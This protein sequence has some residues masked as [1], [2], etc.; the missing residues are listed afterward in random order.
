MKIERTY[1]VRSGTLQPHQ[2]SGSLTISSRIAADPHPLAESAVQPRLQRINRLTRWLD[3]SIRLPIGG[4]TVGWDSIIGLI[5][6]VGDL[7]TGSLSLWI[8]NEARHLGVGRMVLARMLANAGIDMCLGSI[9]VI[10][11]LFDA[12]YKANTRN[13]KL[14]RRSIEPT[15]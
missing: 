10:G 3:S 1:S 12:T 15:A 7:I 4:V 2:P 9:P 8:I 11:D 13:L 14:L 5:P 6:G